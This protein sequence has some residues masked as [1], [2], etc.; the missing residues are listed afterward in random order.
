MEAEEL[1][2]G[3]IKLAA[4]D[5]DDTLLR[6]DLTISQFSRDILQQVQ[7]AGVTVTLATGRMLPSALPYAEQLGFD[8]PLITYQGAL[9]KN[10]FSGEVFYSR[11]LPEEVSRTVIRYA[12]R[13]Q[14][15]VNFY[16]EDKL[17]VE[18]ITEAGKHYERLAGVPFTMVDD[19][20]ALLA[21]G[22]PYKMLLI[23]ERQAIDE[24]REELREFLGEAGLEANLVKSKPTY[25]EV[26]HP[27]A[28]KGTALKKMAEWLKISREQVAAFGDS[29]NDLDMLEYAGYGFAVANACPQVHARAPYITASNNEDGVARALQELAL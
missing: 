2:M 1:R 6:D 28:T 23:D 9:I 29:F 10:A 17:Y 26:N 20:E 22:L 25:L 15:H 19:L 3:K 27:L 24:E 12:R 5:L 13:K 14:I 8:V 18:R 7:K 4:I 11:P 21:G 16:V